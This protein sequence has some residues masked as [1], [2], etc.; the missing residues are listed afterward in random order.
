MIKLRYRRMVGFILLTLMSFVVVLNPPALSVD[1]RQL[2]QQGADRYEAEQ[3]VAAAE[4]WDQAFVGFEAQGD[5]LG[6]ALVQSN[7]SAVYQHLGR[8]EAAEEAI[9]TSLNLLQNSGTVERSPT[10]LNILAKALNTQ[11]RLHWSR[12]RIDAALSVWRQATLAYGQA[13]DTRGVVLSSINQAEALQALGLSV[14]AEAT[15]RQVYEVLQQQ[16]SEPSL[17]ATGL[18]YLGNA[19]RRLGSLNQSRDLLQESLAIATQLNLP[20]LTS[21][22]LLDL[23]NTKR[24]L[25][26]RAIAIGKTEEAQAHQAAAIADY[27]QAA[28]TATLPIDRIQ[29]NLNH[30]SLLAETGQVSDAA[31]LWLLIQPDLTNLSIGRSTVFAYLNAARSLVCLR[32]QLSLIQSPCLQ[33]N[34]QPELGQM[35]HTLPDWINVAQL[36]SNVIQHARTLQDSRAEAFALGQLG[37]LYELTSQWE[38]AQ[39]LTQQALLQ[40]EVIQAPDIRYRWEWQMGRLLEKQGDR[41]GAIAAYTAAFETLKSVR[42]DL[43][44]INSDIQFSFRDNIE[45][46]YR[47]LVD[48]LLQQEAGREP[49]QDELKQAIEVMDALQLAEL[50]NFLRCNVVQ[51]AT[52]FRAGNLTDVVAQVD[53]TAA[54]IYPIILEDRLELVY[55]LPGQ[56]LRHYTTAIG[57]RRV[58]QT[59]TDL[60]I[61]M[62]A[63]NR[64]EVV[65]EKATQVYSWVIRPLEADLAATNTVKTL[66]F[67]LDG[68]LRNIPMAVLYDGEHYLLEK[69][70]ALAIAPSL[71]LIDLQSPSENQ[72]NVLTAGISDARQ[73]EGQTFSELSNVANE[74]QQI[75]AV[76]S[77]ES[78]FNQAFTRTNLQ[79]QMESGDFSAVHIA[80][81]GQFSSDPEETFILAYDEL[82]RS[83][84]LD[85]LLR[86]N[87]QARSDS[88]ELLVLS[89]CET[90][91]GDERATL[92]LAGIALRAGARSTVST[93]WR[94]SDRST[95]ILMGEFYNRLTISEITKAEALHQAQLALFNEYGYKSPYIWAPYVL[96]GNWR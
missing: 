74:L 23:G 65:L 29:A 31:R 94:V 5:V 22:I 20:S 85:G 69:P 81:H 67:V 34:I 27:Q 91:Q 87:L 28:R 7:L 90:A 52:T 95:A 12:G 59:L 64:P 54:L 88:I 36:L 6:Q 53:P 9:A 15:L 75:E 10:F 60:R 8:W 35:S 79:Q 17:K 57:Q 56:P 3:F 44:T 80:T 76:A 37:E 68:A 49:S 11:G 58:E 73:V 30:L 72:L 13:D 4:V 70:Y 86:T 42:S 61:S 32:Q 77:T 24:A 66:V 43:L 38:D 92:G 71:Q 41:S 78:L 50:E 1:A 19:Q 18:W 82:L 14:Q 2:L 21:S 83:Q 62:I 55:K 39:A 84:D 46:V 33:K 45:P 89:A 25:S 51:S 40:T 16:P 63:R 48:L 93:L 96:V 47:R 26:N